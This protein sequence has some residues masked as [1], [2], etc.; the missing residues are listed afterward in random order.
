MFDS[1]S[2][3]AVRL[4]CRI[5]R[6]RRVLAE[7]YGAE[8]VLAKLV[9]LRYQANSSVETTVIDAPAMAFLLAGPMPHLSSNPQ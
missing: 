8:R 3:A 7:K 9:F 2:Q 6:H 1:A 4:V 5:R